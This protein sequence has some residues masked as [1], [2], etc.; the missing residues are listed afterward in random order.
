MKL[1]NK[2]KKLKQSQNAK[3]IEVLTDILVNLCSKYFIMFDSRDE[4]IRVLEVDQV[5]DFINNKMKELRGEK[6]D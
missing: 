2:I 5:S 4:P 6:N 3:A 1:D